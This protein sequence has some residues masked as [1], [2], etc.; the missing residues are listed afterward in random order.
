MDSNPTL[1][2]GSNHWILVSSVGCEDGEVNVYDTFHTELQE[3]PDST[4]CTISRLIVTSSPQ[5]T[6]KMIEVDRQKNFDDCG[7]LAVAIAFDL[8]SASTPCIAA[9][10][11][12]R[13]RAHLIECLARSKFSPFPVIGEQSTSDKNFIFF[14]FSL[15]LSFS[16]LSCSPDVSVN[17]FG[18][19]QWAKIFSWLVR[20]INE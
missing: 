10:D 17:Y 14:A 16:F 19:I 8:L 13:I 11:I 1:D 6:L 3:L 5:L 15:L 9:Y 12:K 2:T 4:I 18:E 7:T 20:E